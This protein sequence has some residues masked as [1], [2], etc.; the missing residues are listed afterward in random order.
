MVESVALV[1]GGVLLWLELIDSAPFRPTIARPYRIGIAAIA[2]WTQ[3]VIAYLMA[4][5]KNSWYRGF[6]HV[7]ER[8][9]SLAADQQLTTALMWFITA[10][11]FV[12][13]VFSNLPPV[14]PVR[15]RS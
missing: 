11:V 4:M 7:S 13:V 3:W 8:L 10:A 15:R 9:L 1:A 2:M 14:A 5:D 6:R 12:P